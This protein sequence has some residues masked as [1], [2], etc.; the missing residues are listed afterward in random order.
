M[1][2]SNPSVIA[3][4]TGLQEKKKL[5]VFDL[6]HTLVKTNSSYSFGKYLFAEGLLSTVDMLY[7]GGCYW[8]HKLLGMSLQDVHHKIF[9]RFFHGLSISSVS[10]NVQKFLD[11]YFSSLVNPIVHD[12]LI[13]HQQSGDY[14]FILSS[15]PDFIVGPIAE[16]FG[17]SQW[18]GTS[19]VVDK[20]CCLCHIGR[21]IEGREKA[22]S[23]S[24]FAERLGV[25]RNSIVAY[26]DSH[27]DLPMLSVVGKIVGVK[28][29]RYLRKMCK[30]NE[31]EIL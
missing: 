9:K 5:C 7:M 18:E 21:L 27:L 11:I 29:D 16:R 8:R 28:P 10:N 24:R 26:T 14:V 30:K 31:W 12:R 15:S 3:V 23:V 22:L 13:S 4:S 19:Y 17:V 1:S 6:D 2:K 20:D 25:S